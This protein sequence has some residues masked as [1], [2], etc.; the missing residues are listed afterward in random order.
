MATTSFLYHTLGLV[1][2]KLLR[3]DYCEGKVVYHVECVKHKRIC[4]N[5]KAPWHCLKIDGQFERNFLGLPVGQKR[6]EVVLHGHVQWCSV[7]GKR[8]R[9]PISFAE[10]SNRHLNSLGR[11][12]VMLCGITQKGVSTSLIRTPTRLMQ[13]AI[14]E[15]FFQSVASRA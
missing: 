5:C 1:G 14:L 8:L 3:T 6:Q 12:A 10:G 2:Y 9:E 13:A 4:R 7:C 15:R 11:F